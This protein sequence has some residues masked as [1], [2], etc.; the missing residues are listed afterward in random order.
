[1]Q[2]YH[3]LSHRLFEPAML[4]LIGI[5][6]IFMLSEHWGQASSWASFIRGRRSARTRQMPS[7]RHVSR[8]QA[9]P[10]TRAATRGAKMPTGCA[11]RAGLDHFFTIV[12]LFE[13]VL[14]MLALGY[15][16]YFTSKWNRYDFFVTC[17][18]LLMLC[19]GPVAYDNF[20]CRLVLHLTRALRIFRVGLCLVGRD[21]ATLYA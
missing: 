10:W 20:F 14:R 15:A 16:T 8:H 18:G 5:N 4:V 1:M 7:S 12:Y 2:M 21:R 3:I 13:C 17:W 6:V 19:L 11:W 9:C